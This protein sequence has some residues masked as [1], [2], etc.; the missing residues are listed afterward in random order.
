MSY[1]SSRIPVGATTTDILTSVNI[2]SIF[3]PSAVAVPL[4]LPSGVVTPLITAL[5]PIGVW[6]GY[7]NLV[8]VGDATTVIELFDVFENDGGATNLAVQSYFVETTL[9]NTNDI[10]IKYPITYSNLDGIN[11]ALNYNIYTIFAGTAPTITAISMTV[12]KVV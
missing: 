10:Y 2:G 9:T 4:V 7:L 5:Y 12:V 11:S 1:A 8:L 6:T 3:S